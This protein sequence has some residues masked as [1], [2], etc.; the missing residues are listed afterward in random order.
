MSRPWVGSLAGRLA[1]LLAGLIVV[2]TV[3]VVV[4]E[5]GVGEAREVDEAEAALD[6]RAGFAADRLQ[7]ALA[8]RRRL[9]TLWA[10]LETSQDLGVDDIDKR[11]SL[12]LADLVSML[13]DRTDAVAGRTGGALL[14][15]S[16][17]A[18]LEHLSKDDLPSYAAMALD[19]S[20]TGV[21]IVAGPDDGAVV[22]TENVRSQV[23][24]EVLGRIVLWTPLRSFL[25]SAIPL[26]LG[27]V[28]VVAQNGSALARGDDITGPSDAYLWG[29]R[30]VETVAGRLVVRV[31]QSRAEV[32][33]DVRAA[34]RQLLVLAAVF[35]L[36]A[37][38]T[39][40][41]VVQ[42]AT[43]GL[44]RLTRAAQELDARDP[45]PLP[46]A[47]A[48]APSEVRVLG[49]A[50]GSMVER[51]RDAREE[52][53]RTESLAA[54]GVL[55]KSLAHEIRT[56][57]SV[58][59]AG[60]EMLQRSSQ[61]E[62]DREVSEMLQAEVE[63]LS[64]LVDDLLVFGRPSP[65]APIDMDLAET[66]ASAVEALEVDAAQNGVS[67]EFLGDRTPLRADPD[68]LR[69]VAVN[70]ISNAVRA[71]ERGGSVVVRSR[72]SDGRAVLEVEDDGV[73][74]PAE[75]L[76][77]IWKPLMTTHRSG[78]GLG[79]PIVRQLVEA[80][81]GTVEVESVVDSGTRMTVSLPSDA[82]TEKS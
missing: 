77:A 70:L 75:N 26:E 21:G 33:D 27:T 15:A 10:E 82:A 54:V 65:P 42:S 47:S 32:V 36:L 31:G 39:M 48:W 3:A 59:R 53:A 5:Y 76:D 58:L 12:S 40:L 72:L 20:T 49:E 67:I 61:S 14:S 25:A 80:H 46:T 62:R 52:L 6:V 69:Q 45:G 79:L 13:G 29:E 56:P 24:G 9:V 41:L 38:P 35:L 11:V 7:R 55:T 44:G 50:M 22:A 23:D 64:R 43:S 18:R 19:A 28:E 68:Q 34:G 81:G 1:L 2:G 8:E 37:L 73:G 60:T 66:A 57:L 63:R 74:I 4:R 51:L 30:S 17:P 16:D 71:C 78:N